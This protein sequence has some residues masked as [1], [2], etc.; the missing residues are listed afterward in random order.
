MLA[1]FMTWITVLPVRE[2][3]ELCEVLFNDSVLS[4]SRITGDHSK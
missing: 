3:A 2:N 1:C 4:I